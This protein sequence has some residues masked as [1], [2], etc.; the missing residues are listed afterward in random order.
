MKTTVCK[1]KR[2]GIYYLM[3]TIAPINEAR[4]ARFD[5]WGAAVVVALLLGTA[6]LVRLILTA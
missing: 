1:V 4:S 3:T 6:G 2:S 5:I